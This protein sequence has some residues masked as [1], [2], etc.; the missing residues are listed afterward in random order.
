MHGVGFFESPFNPDSDATERELRYLFGVSA[1]R[2]AVNTWQTKRKGE[3][4]PYTELGHWARHRTHGMERVRDMMEEGT[5][6]GAK[7]GLAARKAVGG[8][9]APKLACL[10]ELVRNSRAHGV[11]L[12]LLV[13][14]NHVVFLAVSRVDQTEDPFLIE[15][16][17]A[18]A[19][20]VR[21]A[22][23]EVLPGPPAT[24]WDFN[25]YH[26]LNAEALPPL[27]DPTRKMHYWLDG[28]H[29]KEAL[30]DM[31]LR[32]IFGWPMK[33]PA[34]ADYGIRLDLVSKEEL[35]RRF[36]DQFERYR[37]T[38]PDDWAWIESKIRASTAT[39]KLE[40]VE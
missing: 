13:P 33:N 16:R 39:V 18:M 8:A 37:F 35:E 10:K 5:I 25:D 36:E 38:R 11:E 30:G 23:A 22:N 12:T 9:Y 34:G 32:R 29:A 6:P 1:F 17:R 40:H 24:L 20:A 21:E 31:M 3:M 7:R 15:V 19:D 26:P 28:I 2:A 14:P 4:P 27:E